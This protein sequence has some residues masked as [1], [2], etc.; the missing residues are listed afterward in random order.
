MLILSSH[1]D[2]LL[3]DSNGFWNQFDKE[4]SS[5][6][7]QLDKVMYCNFSQDAQSSRCQMN[8]HSKLST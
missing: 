7:D 6:A 5:A 4:T 1:A 2:E 8:M 3:M